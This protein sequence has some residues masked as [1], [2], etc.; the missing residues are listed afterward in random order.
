MLKVS[1]VGA[2]GYAGAELVRLVSRHSNLQLAGLYVSEHSEDQGKRI[3]EL[4]GSLLGVCND[5]LQPLTDV[6]AVAASSDAVFLCTDHKV[7]HDIAPALIQGGCTVYDLSG[8]FRLKDP[9][10]FERFYGF[11]HEHPELLQQAVYALAEYSSQEELK[12][13]RLI[14]LPGCYPTAAQL[15]LKPLLKASLLDLEHL[16]VINAVS[17][18]TGAG[19]KAKLGN[20]F[21]EVSLNVY[22]VF[23]HR[24]LPEIEQ[25]LGAHVIFNPHLGP[26]KRGILETI[27]AKLKVGA[28]RDQVALCYQ[29]MY[30]NSKLVRLKDSMPKLGDVQ[31]LPFCDLG[32]ASSNDGYIVVCSAIDNLLK[33][34]AAQ[35]VQVLN[36]REGFDETEGLL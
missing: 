9:L 1:I 22:G 34:A 8:A 19:R 6:G 25:G 11:K 18:V 36:L 32:I 35:A 21:C 31:G 15:A 29:N 2:S 14:S 5:Y 28:T 10:V 12:Q 27:T 30:R 20:S 17:G 23:N 26:F 4:Y 3:C 16:P 13:T 7:S 24:H 33:G